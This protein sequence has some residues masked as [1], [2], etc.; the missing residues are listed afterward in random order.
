MACPKGSNTKVASAPVRCCGHILRTIQR[1]NRRDIGKGTRTDQSL[2]QTNKWTWVGKKY[3]Q[4]IQLTS[5]LKLASS[6]WD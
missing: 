3:R 6:K 5:T 1:S 4:Q 2:A